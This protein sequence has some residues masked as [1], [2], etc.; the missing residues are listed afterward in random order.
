MQYL[1]QELFSTKKSSTL[2]SNDHLQLVQPPTNLRSVVLIMSW[3]GNYSR[4]RKALPNSGFVWP[5]RF[6]LVW[7]LG[8]LYKLGP[9]HCHLNLHNWSVVATQSPIGHLF[10]Y[11]PAVGISLCQICTEGYDEGWSVSHSAGRRYL[12]VQ[13]YIFDVV[14]SSV[15]LIIMLCVVLQC[16]SHAE[17][18]PPREG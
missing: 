9:G 13:V 16:Q 17:G 5:P 15:K 4:V 18:L 10:P 8:S 2:T 7:W 3:L 14:T 6:F 1:G 12:F 11:K